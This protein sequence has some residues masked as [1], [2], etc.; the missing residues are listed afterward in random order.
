MMVVVWRNVNVGVF[1]LEPRS[2]DGERLV[3]GGLSETVCTIDGESDAL[4]VT[5][6][7]GLPVPD[8]DADVLTINEND[9]VVVFLVSVVFADT[10]SVLDIG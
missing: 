1:D 10:V 3:V 6:P 7:G 2:A 9:D 4:S 5:E 8:A